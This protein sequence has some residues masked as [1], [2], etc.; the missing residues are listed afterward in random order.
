MLLI[1]QANINANANTCRTKTEVW[2][3]YCKRL[4]N[5]SFLLSIHFRSL[6]L[7]KVV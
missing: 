5:Y 7:H 3:P 4:V 1:E 2:Q 6:P